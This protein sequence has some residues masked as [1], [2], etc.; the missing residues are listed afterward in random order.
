[1]NGLQPLH[2]VVEIAPWHPVPEMRALKVPVDPSHSD[3]FSP[4]HSPLPVEVQESQ[5][6][7]PLA[8]R[9]RRS[10]QKLD[11]IDDRW[12][13]DLWWLPQPVTRSYFSVTGADGQRLVLFRD[14]REGR[15]Y[16]QPLSA[17]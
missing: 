14:E 12:E 3:A 11:G 1:M 5:D 4:L 16:R 15:W 9:L 10:W 8:V 6:H 13:F 2:R 17:A 7:R